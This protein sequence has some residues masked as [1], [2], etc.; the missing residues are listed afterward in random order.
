M[1]TGK[2]K[3]CGPQRMFIVDGAELTLCH[4][5]VI[6]LVLFGMMRKQME[7]AL[8]VEKPTI[9]SHF[10]RVYKALKSKLNMRPGLNE[11]L[12]VALIKWSIKHD[13]DEHGCYKGEFL[14]KGVEGHPFGGSDQPPANSD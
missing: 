8:G 7:A 1:E 10:N 14:F 12:I 3:N 9:D 5:R 13:F 6:S 4:M 2:K 11:N